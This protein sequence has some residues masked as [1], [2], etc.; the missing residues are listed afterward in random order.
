VHPERL[1]ATSRGGA[2]VV[3]E[4]RVG[5]RILAPSQVSLALGADSRIQDRSLAI[6][7]AALDFTDPE[8]QR[9]GYRLQGFDKDWLETPTSRRVASYT[10]LPPGDYI[11]HLRSAAPGSGWSTPLD[12]AVRV[13]PAW[14]ELWLGARAGGDHRVI[15]DRRFRAN[16]HGAVAPSPE[17]TRKHRRGTHCAIAAQSESLKS[18][19]YLDVLT[20]LPNRR[21][22][23]DGLR[24]FIAEC[25]RGH[26]DFAMLVIDLDGFKAINDTVGHGAGDAVLVE[27]AARLRTLIRETDLASR[28]GGDEFCVILAQPRDTAAVDRPAPELSRS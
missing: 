21:A 14:Y 25:E 18:M 12:V 3:T 2:I 6:E 15:A 11:L 22:F 10:N 8:L 27:V 16:A 17:G 26:G 1:T 20:G 19:A 9:Y 7:F 4:V 13:Q 24:R 23:D 28:L 5:G